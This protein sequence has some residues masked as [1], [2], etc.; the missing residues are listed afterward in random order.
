MTVSIQTEADRPLFGRRVQI[1]GSA[2]ADADTE[3]TRRAHEI[4]AAT[5][6]RILM[7]GGGLVLAMGKEPVVEDR[8]SNPVGLVFDWTALEVVASCFREACA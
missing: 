3:L 6:R 1:A 8:Q 5:A 4:V 7:A 2:S